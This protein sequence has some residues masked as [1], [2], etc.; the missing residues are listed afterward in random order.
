MSN[1]IFIIVIVV[2]VLI[3]C[4]KTTYVISV[5]HHL[6]CEF[7]SSSWRG[8]LDTTLCD[9]VYSLTCGRSVV[10]SGYSGFPHK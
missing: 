3:V 7:E 6:R 8:V 5:Y 4:F 10:F 1:R 2:L 9:K